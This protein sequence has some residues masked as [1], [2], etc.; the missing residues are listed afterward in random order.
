MMEK[1]LDIHLEEALKAYL[2]TGIENQVEYQKFYL[3]SIVTYSTVIEG[4]TITEIEN[5]LFFDEDIAAK[6]RKY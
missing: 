4:S 1:N 2:T 5:Q 6:G 3:Y